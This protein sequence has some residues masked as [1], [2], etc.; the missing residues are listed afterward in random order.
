MPTISLYHST[1]TSAAQDRYIRVLH[2][3]NRIVTAWETAS[4]V[5]GLRRI[6]AQTVRNCL[7]ENAVRARRPYFGAELRRRLAR[8]RWCNRVRGW[9]LQ[10]RRRVW[11]SDESRFML[12][13]RDG[14]RRVY[15]RRNERFARNYVLGVA[16]FGNHSAARYRDEVLPPHMLPAMNFYR[17]VFQHDKARPHTDRATVDFLA[18][19]NVTVLPWP[20]KSLDLNPIEHLWMTWIDACA[21]VNQLRKLCK[22]CSRFLRKNGENFTRP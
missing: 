7:R 18:N 17:E 21:I 5:P 16:N 13:K 8:V 2:L 3:R 9:D 19:Q 1:D 10:K 12:H 14:R 6:S 15:R 11:F 22:N 20:F 4:N